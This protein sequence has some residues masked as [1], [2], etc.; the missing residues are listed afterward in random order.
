MAKPT[1]KSLTKL[2]D[3][4]GLAELLGVSVSWVHKRTMR[5]EIPCLYIQG[6]VLRFEADAIARWIQSQ[7]P[8]R[9]K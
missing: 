2:L 9:S 8:R 5:K 1:T 6:K 4:R 7:P 3:V